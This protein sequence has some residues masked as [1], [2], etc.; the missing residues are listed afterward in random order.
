MMFIKIIS[1]YVKRLIQRTNSV[2]KPYF[3]GNKSITVSSESFLFKTVDH[4]MTVLS[5][6]LSQNINGSTEEAVITRF[7]ATSMGFPF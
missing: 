5:D 4:E 3:P 7:D 6:P 1:V 2:G